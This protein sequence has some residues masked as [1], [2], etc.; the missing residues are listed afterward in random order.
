[1][2]RLSPLPPLSVSIIIASLS[3]SPSLSNSQ[4]TKAKNE[5]AKN[6]IIFR[7]DE[8]ELWA[9]YELVGFSRCCV[10]M[11]AETK[12]YAVCYI[13]YENKSIRVLT[14]FGFSMFLATQV[15]TCEFGRIGAD[16]IRLRDDELDIRLFEK[17]NDSI[18]DAVRADIEKKRGRKKDDWRGLVS[19]KE[20]RA[21]KK[22]KKA[23]TA[24]KN[25]NT[26]TKKPKPKKAKKPKKA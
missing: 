7:V 22:A 8:T 14:C 13:P 1:M 3:P 20:D 2:R 6:N 25:S 12:E 16:F 21:A 9:Y 5:L 18:D 23:N 4:W 15:L 19:V 24:T 11:N 10:T 17:S 26:T